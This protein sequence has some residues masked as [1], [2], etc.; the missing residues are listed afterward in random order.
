MCVKMWTENNNNNKE[1]NKKQKMVSI[2]KL[3][4]YS[5]WAWIKENHYKN[6]RKIIIIKPV[7]T[8]DIYGLL[9]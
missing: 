3:N 1:T 7:A 9:K 8:W 2:V 6:K 5:L 4:E